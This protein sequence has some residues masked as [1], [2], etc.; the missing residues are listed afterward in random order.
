MTPFIVI[1][2]IGITMILYGVFGLVRYAQ[3][4]EKRGYG[5]NAHDVSTSTYGW[6]SIEK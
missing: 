1:I 5:V 4:L 3:S 6:A 2:F